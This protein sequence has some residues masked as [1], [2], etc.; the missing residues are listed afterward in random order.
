[1]QLETKSESFTVHMHNIPDLL[2]RI[3]IY[4]GTMQGTY[5]VRETTFTL[6]IRDRSW[7]YEFKHNKL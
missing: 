4:C 6:Q 7:N 1:M 2:F 3:C 5:E